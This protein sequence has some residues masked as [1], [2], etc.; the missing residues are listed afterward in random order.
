MTDFD[1][2]TG[3]FEGELREDASQQVIEAHVK[4]HAADGLPV[5]SRSRAASNLI[6]MLEDGDFDAEL[7][8]QM[9][10]LFH[11]LEAHAHNNKGQAKG[12]ITLTLD[13]HLAHGMVVVTP[14][15]KVAKPK[16]K[17]DGTAL[18]IGEDGS[19][20][21]NPPGQSQMFG[22]RAKDPDAPRETRDI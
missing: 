21:R 18:F 14:D 13:M 17:R 7:S 9:R 3:E 6:K 5:P 2:T 16:Q 1:R 12:K 10:G 22:S 4:E 19:A 11:A 8:H 15:Y 20:G